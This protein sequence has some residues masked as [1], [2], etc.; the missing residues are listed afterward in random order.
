MR[1]NNENDNNANEV[2]R[3]RNATVRNVDVRDD[4]AWADRVPQPGQD[5]AAGMGAAGVAGAGAAGAGM[6]AAD[7]AAGAAGAGF[8][9][10]AG[11]AEGAGRDARESARRQKALSFGD[12]RRAQD[13]RVPRKKWSAQ[14]GQATRTSS[15]R[16]RAQKMKEAREHAR[17]NASNRM[18]NTKAGLALA[19]KTEGSVAL[20]GRDV[21]KGDIIKFIALIVTILLMLAVFVALWPAIKDE[22]SAGGVEG[23]VAT[24]RGWGPLGVLVLLLLQFLQV[25]VAFIPGEAVQLAAGALYGPVGGSILVLVGCALSSAVVFT[26]VHK[27]GAPFVQTMVS[28]KYIEKFREFEHSGKLVILVFVLYLIPGLPK[29]VFSYLVPLTTMRLKPFVTLT[30]IARAPGVFASC[31][32]ANGLMN[33]NYVSAIIVAVVVVALFALCIWKRAELMEWLRKISQ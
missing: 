17:E 27:L 18:K 2:I 16:E 13:V 7:G 23:L 15:V 5:G 31:F 32:V 4:R 22:F 10:A 24:V 3:V 33:G 20:A 1:T 21:Q 11:A 30:T 19:R 8:G 6:G 28:G 12:V 9:D 25:L 26:L 14:S 29:D